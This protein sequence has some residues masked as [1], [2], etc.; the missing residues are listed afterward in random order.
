M[1]QKRIRNRVSNIM[2]RNKQTRDNDNLLIA[3]VLKEVYGT[4]D[5]AKIA[6]LTS[7]GICESITRSRR[8]VQKNNP[9]LASSS[10]TTKARRRKEEKYRELKGDI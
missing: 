9:F 6:E 4:T 2:T 1:K 5:M 7:E 3:K 8:F 10:K